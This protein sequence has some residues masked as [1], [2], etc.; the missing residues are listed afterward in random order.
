MDPYL[1]PVFFAEERSKFNS[2]I[3]AD[4]RLDLSLLSSLAC[5]FCHSW[6]AF[7]SAI[8]NST[9]EILLAAEVLAAE[10]LATKVLA[11]E[12]LA[13]GVLAAGVL[14]AGMLTAE[15]LAAG[16][17]AAEDGWQNLLILPYFA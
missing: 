15:V 9:S 4:T 14:A 13:A 5:C 10:V 2:M 3:N 17:L 16:V 12:V 11:A 7:H 1:E 8:I 6:R